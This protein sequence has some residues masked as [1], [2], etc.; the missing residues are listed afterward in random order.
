MTNKD[1][2]SLSKEQLIELVD[3]LESKKKYGLVWDE[4]RVPEKVVLDCQRKLPVLTEI[5]DKSITTNENEPTHILIES[6]NFHSLSVLS[7]A[8]RNKVGLIYID[9]PY[10]TGKKQNGNTTIN[11]LINLTHLDILNGSIL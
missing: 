1:Y 5:S 3:K 8:H 4:E 7:Y 6:D 2:S 11:S 10:N 9:P